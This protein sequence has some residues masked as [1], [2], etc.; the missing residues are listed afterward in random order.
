MNAGRRV[1]VSVLMMGL[2]ATVPAMAA[3]HGGSTMPAMKEHGGSTMMAA[4]AADVET[5]KAAANKLRATDP[6]L[7]AKLDALAAKCA[8]ACGVK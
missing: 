8:A 6:D 4:S 2:V 3:E 1:A 7:A 5:L